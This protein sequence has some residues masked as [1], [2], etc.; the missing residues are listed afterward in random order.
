L[1]G[2]VTVVQ[3]ESRVTTSWVGSFNDSA[4][5]RYPLEFPS[6]KWTWAYDATPDAALMAQAQEEANRP[7]MP[8]EPGKTGFWTWRALAGLAERVGTSTIHPPTFD[9][10]E[11]EGA[12][13][14]RYTI[15]GG[16]AGDLDYRAMKP[17]EFTEDKPWRSLAAVWKDL[18]PGPYSLVVTPLDAAGNALP[19]KMR[20]GIMDKGKPG[21]P[22]PVG[23]ITRELDR[24]P[25]FK[26]PSFAGP[27]CTRAVGMS[28]RIGLAWSDDLLHWEMS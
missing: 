8:G 19:G 9:I 5:F 7:V 17:V 3:G 13:K 26:K 12:V 21:D 18:K 24:I 4:A 6:N 22:T 2:T 25:V 27:S 15:T 10:K 28:G 16:K 14:Y 11:T 1:F 23:W 20:V